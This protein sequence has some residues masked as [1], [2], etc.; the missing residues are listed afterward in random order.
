MISTTVDAASNLR[1]IIQPNRSLSWRQVKLVYLGVVAVSM[2]VAIAFAL[3]GFWPVLPFAGVEL[4]GLGAA[5]YT[6]ALRGHESEVVHVLPS[7]VTVEKGRRAPRAR[8]E[9]A[10]PWTRV[11]LLRPRV[12]WY[13]TRLTLGSHGRSVP[14]GEFLNEEERRHLAGFLQS[15]I[16]A[17][18]GVIT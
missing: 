3:R 16:A 14:L 9:F 6:C 1:V 2:A 15:K 5:L 12:R 8:W 10:R 18:P 13:P 17:P 7:T 11:R 4:L